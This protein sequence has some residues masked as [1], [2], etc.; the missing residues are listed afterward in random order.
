M[1]GRAL[2]SQ[3]LEES[4]LVTFTDICWLPAGCQILWQEF[5]IE[6]HQGIIKKPDIL[7]LIFWFHSSSML[8]NNPSNFR[9]SSKDCAPGLGIVVEMKK[10]GVLVPGILVTCLEP[11][12]T[13]LFESLASFSL[14]HSILGGA[15]ELTTAKY[16][17]NMVWLKTSQNPATARRRLH[18]N[19]GFHSDR[20]L[21]PSVRPSAVTA[22]SPHTVWVLQSWHRL[23]WNSHTRALSRQGR[24]RIGNAGRWQVLPLSMKNEF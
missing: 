16:H 8:L 1:P 15:S 23:I 20:L 5:N 11:R 10:N 4:L 12:L 13:K 21:Q 3:S 22:P 24:C 9:E 17:W 7:T 2:F 18:W 6:V 14:F 19:P